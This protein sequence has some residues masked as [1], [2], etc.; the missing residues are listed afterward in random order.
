MTGVINIGNTNNQCAVFDDFTLRKE[1]K[2]D[3]PI[4]IKEFFK[5]V[6]EIIMISVAPGREEKIRDIIEIP[7]ITFPKDIAEM[8]Y[9][10]DAGADRLAN[11]LAAMESQGL[12]VIVVDCGSAITIDLFTEPSAPNSKSQIR[13]EGGAILPG[14]NWYFS[15]LHKGRALP[16]IIPELQNFIGKSTS[17]CIKLGAYGA[18]VGGIKEILTL[19]DYQDKKL[20]FTG[21]DGKIFKGFFDGDYDP[22]LTIKGGI[23]AYHKKCF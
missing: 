7:I 17:G 16:K 19:L 14:L 23:I 18:L 22:F 9:E 3:D 21:G 13:F 8:A 6:R 2:I 10:S 20:I 5:S 4:K 11:G 1:E 12:P 15:S